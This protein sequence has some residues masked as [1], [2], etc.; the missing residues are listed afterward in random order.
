M[1]TVLDCFSGI[2]GFSKGLEATGGFRT[3][4]FIEIDPFCRAVLAKHWPEVPQHDDITTRQFVAGEADVVCGGFPCQDISNAGKRA[5]ITGSRS[6]LW[7]ELVRAIRVVRPKYAV[8]E[9]VAALLDDGM[10]VVLGDLAESGYDAE[11]DCIPASAVGAPHVRDRVWILSYASRCRL[12]GRGES[13]E[14]NCRQ[15]AKRIVQFARVYPRGIER[16]G[17]WQTECGIR[18]VA[19]RVANWVDRI[20][21]CGNAVVPQCVEL[22]GRAIME[23][24]QCTTT[25]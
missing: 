21:A 8:V 9:N 23:A 17:R 5:G 6:G 22:I 11:W 16:S 10:G 7:R 12:E 4:G 15:G 14:N 1:L 18:R 13:V 20:R 24:D 25:T 19:D 3:V 2:G